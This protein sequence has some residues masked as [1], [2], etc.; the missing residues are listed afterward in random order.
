MNTNTH[1]KTIAHF[2]LKKSVCVNCMFQRNTL[3]KRK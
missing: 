2:I 1:L 3:T